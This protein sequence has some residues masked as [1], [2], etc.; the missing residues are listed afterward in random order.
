MITNNTPMIE[1]KSN[2]ILDFTQLTDPGQ[3]EKFK[4]L[5]DSNK[6]NSFENVIG[7]KIR[8]DQIRFL[9]DSIPSKKFEQLCYL[10]VQ[11]GSTM[12][13]YPIAN[14]VD[15]KGGTLK[16]IRNT[17]LMRHGDAIEFLMQ[18]KYNQN[19]EFL[20]TSKDFGD[21]YCHIEEF[22]QH[23]RV[24]TINEMR[25]N[26]NTVCNFIQKAFPLNKVRFTALQAVLT[27]LASEDAATANTEFSSIK[28]VN[29]SCATPVK[30]FL[31][32]KFIGICVEENRYISETL[33]QRLAMEAFLTRLLNGT[34][35]FK[36]HGEQIET[37]DACV[38]NLLQRG[39]NGKFHNYL[40][41]DSSAKSSNADGS[42][43]VYSE[44][45]SQE[46]LPEE[47]KQLI[48]NNLC[49]SN[50]KGE[51]EKSGQGYLLDGAKFDLIVDEY[52]KKALSDITDK[53]KIVT[54]TV[55]SIH[56]VF[57]EGDGQL[58][59]LLMV[60]EIMSIDH[61]HLL[62]KA[63]ENVV[64]LDE[65]KKI[66]S[67]YV[68]NFRKNCEENYL[69]KYKAIS[70]N[71]EIIEKYIQEQFPYSEHSKNKIDHA[72]VLWKALQDIKP[73]NQDYDFT[74]AI[75]NTIKNYRDNFY[76]ECIQDNRKKFI[77]N[78]FGTYLTKNCL[79]DNKNADVLFGKIKFRKTNDIIK[80]LQSMSMI[81]DAFVK[82]Q[83]NRFSRD[84]ISFDFSKLA[85]DFFSNCTGH[86]FSQ[87]ALTAKNQNN[88]YSDETKKK[89]RGCCGFLNSRNSATVSNLNSMHVS[90]V[91]PSG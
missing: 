78:N 71:V 64:S 4:V 73:R 88:R 28:F 13:T 41:I 86:G 46:H 18:K 9:P 1:S 82:I 36:N 30:D 68:N 37:I 39:L 72:K 77:I 54:D 90:S 34:T 55:N 51:L 76:K 87:N 69:I 27:K 25:G 31:M 22:L 48:Q 3:E 61:K 33:L 63:L 81:P 38:S 44:F 5:T 84:C 50:E 11:D 83:K 89:K 56:N 15:N 65:I 24:V 74:T 12:K 91:R 6:Q 20:Y 70:E 16:M 19:S 66:C 79:V 17:L 26:V 49:K 67:D 52:K 8:V 2:V 60:E 21:K 57:T 47:W 42:N 58:A 62:Y 40:S 80:K 43:S 75:N 7:L 45:F 32:Q 53:L 29:N 14:N 85:V 10:Q 23:S 35:T 59:E